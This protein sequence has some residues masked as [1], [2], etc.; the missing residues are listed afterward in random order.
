MAAGISAGYYSGSTYYT[1]LVQ[2]RTDPNVD[3]N[4]LKPATPAPGIDPNSAYSAKWEGLVTPSY[5]ETYTFSIEFS[6]GG[7]LWVN[8][9]QM[10]PILAN[11]QS[12]Y[13]MTAALTAGVPVTL[14]VEY[15]DDGS[16]DPQVC[17]LSW[18]SLSQASQIIPQSV[19]QTAPL[20]AAPTGLTGTVSG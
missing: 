14:Q 8:G 19:L 15:Y 3:L 6:K 18:S 17:I 11:S 12:T 9:V 20:L 2:T 5:T 7:D 16:A 1:D 13:T 10:A 4:L